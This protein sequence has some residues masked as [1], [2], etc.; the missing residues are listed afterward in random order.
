MKARPFRFG[1]VFSSATD[2]TRCRELTRCLEGEGFGALLV[3]DHYDDDVRSQ[4]GD[5][6][7][8]TFAICPNDARDEHMAFY[9][10]DRGDAGCSRSR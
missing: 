5:D 9:H 1:M 6:S 7:T 4:S 2:R 8:W 3:A 10:D